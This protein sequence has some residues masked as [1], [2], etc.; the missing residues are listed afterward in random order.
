M[1]EVRSASSDDEFARGNPGKV[2][3]GQRPPG[4]SV[5][6]RGCERT[7]VCSSA[8]AFKICGPIGFPRFA[9]IGG[10]RLF[11]LAEIRADA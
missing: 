9:A 2:F 11:P 3:G 1:G 5:G 7:R 4:L 6:L 8:N 10:E